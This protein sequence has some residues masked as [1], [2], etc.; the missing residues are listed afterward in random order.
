M[1]F[2]IEAYHVE[3]NPEGETFRVAHGSVNHV[4]SMK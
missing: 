3:P 4:E 1:S 2:Y